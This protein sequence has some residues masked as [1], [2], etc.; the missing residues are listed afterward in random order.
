[1]CG[2][3]AY[4][5]ASR[6]CYGTYQAIHGGDDICGVLRG[7]A[8][9]LLQLEP[10]QS[11]SDK[12][13]YWLRPGKPARLGGGEKAVQLRRSIYTTLTIAQRWSHR[14][15]P[16]YFKLQHQVRPVY[17]TSTDGANQ[18][19]CPRCWSRRIHISHSLSP[20]SSQFIYSLRRVGTSPAVPRRWIEETIRRRDYYIQEN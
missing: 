9:S 17:Q 3:M 13:Q 11:I 2:P 1:M 20:R 19:V 14:D 4:Q 15:P 7:T 16:S 8:E 6:E 12:T 18:N 5:G 10:L